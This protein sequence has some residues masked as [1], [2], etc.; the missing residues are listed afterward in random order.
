MDIVTPDKLERICELDDNL[1]KS[2][3][4]GEVVLTASVAALP[5]MVKAAVLDQVALFEVFNEENDPYGM[6]DYGSFDYR[7]REFFFKI[8]FFTLEPSD[9]P[10]D[11]TDPKKALRIMTVGLVQDL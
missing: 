10:L 11:L 2:F 5:N 1:R 6:H 7:S 3:S 4:G 8:E 9:V